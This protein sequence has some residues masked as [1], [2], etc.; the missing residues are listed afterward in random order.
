M[1]QTKRRRGGAD[2]VRALSYVCLYDCNHSRI[3]KSALHNIVRIGY[4]S[5]GTPAFDEGKFNQYAKWDVAIYICEK[6]Y[7]LS[8]S[9]C[10][11]ER[12]SPKLYKAMG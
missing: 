1:L 3:N 4:T 10:V 6:M 12:W 5:S 8:F 2:G 9:C 11:A 7:A